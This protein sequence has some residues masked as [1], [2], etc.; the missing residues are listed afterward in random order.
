[1]TDPIAERV[2]TTGGTT[3]RSIGH[4]APGG[5]LKLLHPWPGQYPPP[6]QRG[7]G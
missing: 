4:M 1:M 6:L 2:R 3:V 7:D 5:H